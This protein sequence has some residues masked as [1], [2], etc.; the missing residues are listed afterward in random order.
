[1][2][3]QALLNISDCYGNGFTFAWLKPGAILS[4]GYFYLPSLN[5]VWNY[6]QMTETFSGA[7]YHLLLSY[8]NSLFVY[9]NE[10]RNLLQQKSVNTDFLTLHFLSWVFLF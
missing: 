8:A 1:M 2:P 7:S 4:L 5:S 6:L 9:E 10:C 3:V